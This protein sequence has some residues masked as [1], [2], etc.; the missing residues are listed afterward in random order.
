[1]IDLTEPRK[2]P[3]KVGNSEII[4]TGTKVSIKSDE[5]D[6]N[7]GSATANFKGLTKITGS[8]VDIN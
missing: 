4:I 5:I 1:M 6:I 3:L 7:G 2:L 8:Q